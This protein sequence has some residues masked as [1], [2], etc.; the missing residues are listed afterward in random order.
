MNIIKQSINKD[1]KKISLALVFLFLGWIAQAVPAFPDKVVFTQPG[2][3]ITVTVFLKGDERVHWAETMDGYSLL[4]GDDGAL[5]YAQ[6]NESGEMV[7]SDHLATEI[8]DRSDEVNQFLKK[9]PIH[10]RF[11][12]NQIKT[13]LEIWETV[14]KAK[15]GPKTMSDVTGNKKFLVILF[16]FQDRGF[17]INK[18]AFKMLFNQVNYNLHNST[19]SVHDYYMDVSGGLFSLHVDV[20]GP[21]IGSEDM[22][23]Y[24]SNDWGA[25]FFAREAVDSAAKDVDFSDYDNDGDGYIDGLHIIFA[26]YGEEAGG[27]SNA[28]WSHKWNIYNPPTYNNTVVDL[29]SCSPEL[30]G[31]MN[32]DMTHIGVICHE[33]GHV[34][35]APDYYDTDYGSNGEYPGLGKWDIMSSGSWNQNGVSP[36]HHNP[37]TKIYIYHWATCHTINNVQGT[38]ALDAAERSNSDF[39]R[40]NTSTQGDFF[41]LENRQKIKW[42]RP[43]PGHGMLV[44]HGHPDIQGSR[45]SNSTHP[46][47][48]YIFTHSYTNDTFPTSEPSS[49]GDLNTANTPYP[50]MN[51]TIDSVTDNSVPWLRPWSKVANGTPIRYISENSDNGKVYFIINSGSPDPLNVNAEPLT[52]HSIEMDWEKYGNYETLVAMNV[53]GG[54]IGTPSGD[55]NV[56]DTLDGGGIVVYLGDGHSTMIDSLVRGQQYCFKVFSKKNNGEYSTGVPVCCQTLDCEDSPWTTEDFD[57]TE[58]GQLPDCWHGSW[59]VADVN[60]DKAL[61]CSG[62]GWQ[63]VTSKSIYTD[64]VQNMVLKLRYS[65][66]SNSSENNILRIYYRREPTAEWEV[67]KAYSWRF[68]MADWN[69]TYIQLDNAGAGSQIRF[70]AMTTDSTTVAIDDVT[71]YSGNLVFATSDD[72]GNIEPR[73]YS[74][75]SAGDSITYTIQALAGYK[76]HKITLDGTKVADTSYTTNDDGSVVYTLKNIVE[77]HTVEV[78][79]KANVDLYEAE[80][81]A[82]KVWPNPTNGIIFIEYEGTTEAM[83]YDIRGHEVSRSAIVG[84]LGKIDVTAMPQGIYILRCGEHVF[85]V[86]KK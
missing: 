24:G 37:Y 62:D 72:N 40:I 49:Y 4:H 17:V 9:T 85:K 78:T 3:D 82:L 19:G 57:S 26:G 64:S 22:A 52:N 80:T 79:F 69:D 18:M 35:G 2:R 50:R 6:L 68:G 10:L 8:E 66:S 44:Y 53:A 81:T 86:I 36:A 27:G 74:I 28:I 60:G 63:K 47:Q 73:G 38:I 84:G 58:V 5:Y 48:L 61:V 43:L 39:L 56:G 75:V 42:D 31:N 51:A 70:Y 46:Q 55:L 7:T 33:L 15:S 59:Q 41:L 14:E 13:M 11:N 20:A 21:Y 77:Q 71:I 1:M 65:F 45:V 25:Q 30:N 16:G 32:E 23:Y 12:Q 29:Y 54:T 76:M 83:L 67:M 34:F